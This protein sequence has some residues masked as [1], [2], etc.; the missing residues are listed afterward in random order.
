MQK[1]SIKKKKKKGLKEISFTLGDIQIIGE[2]I[3]C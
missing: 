1:G 3:K 2:Q